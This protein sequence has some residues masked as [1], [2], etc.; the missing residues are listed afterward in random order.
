MNCICCNSNTKLLQY[1][2]LMYCNACYN[3]LVEVFL[4]TEI[5]NIRIKTYSPLV[6]I[7]N[8]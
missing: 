4:K 1:N 7:I 5:E 3:T 6:K 2:G 8:N